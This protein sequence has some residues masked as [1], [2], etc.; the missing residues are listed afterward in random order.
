VVITDMYRDAVGGSSNQPEGG[1]ETAK[2]I[3]ADHPDVPVIIYA[4]RYSQQHGSEPVRAPVIA[5]TNDTEKVFELVTQ[6]AR[7]KTHS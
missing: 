6:I 5:N 7:N 1:L 2:I 4:G 3:Q